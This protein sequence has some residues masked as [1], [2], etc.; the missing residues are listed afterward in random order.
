MRQIA[1]WFFCGFRGEG[2]VTKQSPSGSI[3]WHSAGIG[4]L[5]VIRLQPRSRSHRTVRRYQSCR[6]PS[7]NVSD[8]TMQK[9]G[10]SSISRSS[11]QAIQ[12]AQ[13][14]PAS[15]PKMVWRCCFM[16]DCRLG[17]LSLH[18]K[19]EPCRVVNG[20]DGECGPGLM[21]VPR[22]RLARRPEHVDVDAAKYPEPPA[23]Y[24]R[25]GLD[26]GIGFSEPPATISKVG[27]GMTRSGGL[28]CA[29][30]TPSCKGLAQISR[31]L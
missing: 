31:R 19:N 4:Q 27:I 17:E 24:H 8:P 7:A 12:V 6:T 23:A 9:F 26:R 30:V 25:S 20:V 3:I 13:Q 11:T 1:T 2:P 15:K 5:T 10:T 28:T 21:N 18:P 14:L 22:A 16:S 29:S